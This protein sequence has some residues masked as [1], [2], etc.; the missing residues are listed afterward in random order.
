V[1]SLRNSISCDFEIFFSST[2]LVDW[3]NF[4]FPH[5]SSLFLRRKDATRRYDVTSREI[6]VIMFGKIRKAD[7]DG[8]KSII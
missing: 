2:I 1:G 5:F 8:E 3:K 6:I 7:L 4:N